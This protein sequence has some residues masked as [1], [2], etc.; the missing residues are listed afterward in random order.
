MTNVKIKLTK[1]TFILNNF[2]I[3]YNSKLALQEKVL[4]N[5]N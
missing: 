3:S 4:E 2:G 1:R 5:V